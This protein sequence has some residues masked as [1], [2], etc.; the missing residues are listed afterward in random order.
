LTMGLI[1]VVRD[2]RSLNF[3]ATKTGQITRQSARRL[4]MDRAEFGGVPA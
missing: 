3:R 1:L 4:Q 2:G